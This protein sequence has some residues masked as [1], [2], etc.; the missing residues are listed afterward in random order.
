MEVM[1]IRGIRAHQLKKLAN[2]RMGKPSRIMGIFLLTA[3]VLTPIDT[4]FNEVEP[5][6]AAQSDLTASLSA[7]GEMFA[8]TS[9]TDLTTENLDSLSSIASGTNLAI[10]TIGTLNSGTISAQSGGTYTNPTNTTYTISGTNSIYADAAWY[11]GSGG[12]GKFIS[13]STSNASASVVGGMRITLRNLDGVTPADNTYR[14][15]GFWWS[16]GNSPNIVRLMNDGVAQATFT[17][18]NLLGQLGSAP[19]PRVSNDYFGNP[20]TSYNTDDTPCPANNTCGDPGASE[21]YAYVHLRYAPGFDEIQF[22]GKGFEF[23][24]IS[25]RRFVPASD[26]GEV[27][28]VGSGVVSSCSA[29]SN[30]NAQYVLRNG[31]FE[32]DY[33]TASTGTASATLASITT[34]NTTTDIAKWVRY[35]GGPYQFMNLYDAGSSNANRVPFWFTSASDDKI[36]LQ[37]QVAGAESSAARNGSLYFDLFGPRPADGSVHAEINANER[38]ALFQDI[39]TTAGEKITWTIKHR[40]RFFGAGS[41]TQTSSTTTD[42]RDKFEILIGPSSGTLVSQTPTR[43]RNPDVIWNTAN[44]SYGNN[45]WTTFSTSTSGHTAGTM[46]T[47]LEDGWVLYTGTYTVPANQTSTR[48]SFSSRGTGTVG[49]LIDDIGFDPII[50]CPRTITIQ[51]SA[52]ATYSYNP[53]SDTRIPNYSY[54]DTT[55][56]T[57]VSVNGGTGTATL[58]NGQVTLSSDTVGTYQVLFTVTDVNSETSTSTITVNVED[59]S[60]QFPNVLPVDPRVNQ[61]TLPAATIT[62]PTNAMVCYQQVADSSGTA[63]SGSPTLSVNRS[64]STANVSLTSGTNLWQFIGARAS[65]QTQVPSITFSGLDS[66]P[67]VTTASKFVRV[68]LSAATT[69]GSAP[70]FTATTRV[71]ELKPITVKLSVERGVSVQ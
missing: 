25:I 41:T 33:F 42:D 10:G 54:P 63:L 62:G 22:M 18:V 19:N 45:A 8:P 61:I 66:A 36:E 30:Q 5:A 16:A 21:P 49:N 27:A 56:L 37:R 4:E 68:G 11:G 39:V 15:I 64:S 20:S 32:D 44:A 46:Y 2:I 31:S 59:S 24:Q 28:I 53:L 3:V 70:C 51:K 12:S 65:V 7:A 38:A 14:Y 13:I 17:T 50:A 26:S 47:K 60:A 40:G 57:S 71:I 35:S 1:S 43:K 29:F 23:D 34:S 55:T 48:F 67:L 9:F 52:T 6:Q 58:S 69:F